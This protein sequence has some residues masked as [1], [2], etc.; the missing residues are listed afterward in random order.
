MILDV[1]GYPEDYLE[2]YTG[3]IAQVTSADVLR[4]AR[5]YLDLDHLIILVV[6]NDAYF[7]TPLQTLGT[8]L[9]VDPSEL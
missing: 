4:V 7:E 9:R 1:R 6:G 2:Q 8:V 5:R 3:R